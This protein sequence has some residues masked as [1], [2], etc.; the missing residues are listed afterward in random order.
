MNVPEPDDI[1]IRVDQRRRNM[2]L[3]DA[4]P[5]KDALNEDKSSADDSEMSFNRIAFVVHLRAIG[6][7]DTRTINY[8]ISYNVLHGRTQPGHCFI[9][10]RCR[11]LE[12]YRLE[13]IAW[14]R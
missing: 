8:T 2:L 10:H 12:F 7:Q 3:I 13:S 11:A 6:A 1:I 5:T 9:P 4:I 14:S